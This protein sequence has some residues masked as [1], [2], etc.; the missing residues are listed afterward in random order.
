MCFDVYP[1]EHQELAPQLKCYIELDLGVG[2]QIS[3]LQK[4]HNVKFSF[5]V[6]LLS[7]TWICI[8]YAE[9][10]RIRSRESILHQNEEAQLIL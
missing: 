2:N 9:E 4:S 7:T 3:L 6:T 5:Y 1:N 10:W 8:S